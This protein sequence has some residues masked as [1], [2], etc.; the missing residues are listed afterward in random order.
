M[1]KDT[2]YSI[3]T[4]TN[5]KIIP[6]FTKQIIEVE[7]ADSDTSGTVLGEMVKTDTI[8][9]ASLDTVL[10]DSLLNLSVK[11]NSQIPLDQKGYFSFQTELKERNVIQKETIFVESEP[12]IINKWIHFGL[13]AAAGYG[14]I[15][16]KHD[17]FIGLGVMIG[18]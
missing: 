2:I 11:Y 5:E 9:V 15:N 3:K 17:V 12:G 6:V 14:T 10:F 7:R 13:V 1:E 4:I 16:K 8:Y 18:L